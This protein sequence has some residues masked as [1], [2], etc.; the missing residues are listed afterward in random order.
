MLDPK[1][2][3]KLDLG[4]AKLGDIGYQIGLNLK[5]GKDNISRQKALWDQGIKLWQLLKVL[6]RHVDTTTTPPT[7]IRI[8]EETVNRLLLCLVEIGNLDQLPITPSLMRRRPIIL[9]KGADGINGEDG[10]DG[11][12]AFINVYPE[13]GETEVIVREE[14][15]GN[16][17]NYYL[18]VDLYRAPLVTVSLAEPKVYMK[19]VVL[20]LKSLSVTTE[21]GNKNIVDISYTDADVNDLLQAVLNLATVNGPVQ[22]VINTISLENVSETTTYTA[23]V[24]DETEVVEASDTISFYFP[25]LYGDSDAIGIDLWDS[26]DKIV[27]PKQTQGFA[28]DGLNKY[29]WIAYPASYGTVVIKDENGFVV[30]DEF[31]ITTADITSAGLDDNWTES[32]KICRTTLKTDIQGTF[33]IEFVA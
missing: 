28:L 2:S 22:P 7:L 12:N 9:N 31:T 15:V 20:A 13:E 6:L 21:K 10:N 25:Y 26:L 8:S 3:Q 30:T 1:L 14:I 4:Y 27:G 33:T 11:S 5:K 23:Q 19:G 17:K 24:D 18:T 32:Y 16:T 29:F